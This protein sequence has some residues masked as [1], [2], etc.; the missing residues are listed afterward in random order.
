VLVVRRNLRSSS[1]S[2]RVW[3]RPLASCLIALTSSETNSGAAPSFQAAVVLISSSIVNILWY[4]HGPAAAYFCAGESLC[5]SIFLAH[6]TAV[7][8]QSVGSCFTS[9]R[10]RYVFFFVVLAQNVIRDA[11][12]FSSRDLRA[13]GGVTCSKR[14]TRKFFAS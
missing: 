14:L 13:N 1:R 3:S 12:L 8:T 5:R 9:L 11:R 10:C 6:N 7:Q 2:P 4:N